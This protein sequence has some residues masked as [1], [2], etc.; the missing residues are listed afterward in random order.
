VTTSVLVLAVIGTGLAYVLYFR[1]I[2]QLGAT[3]AAGVDYLVPLFA[4]LLAV[5]L[6]GEKVT[7]HLLIGGVTVAVA[8]GYDQM[9][10]RSAA[11]SLRDG[12]RRGAS[13]CRSPRSRAI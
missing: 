11:W 13:R 2:A 1:L 3:T 8:I 7:W 10:G 6:L 4:V 5:A 12:R 9:R